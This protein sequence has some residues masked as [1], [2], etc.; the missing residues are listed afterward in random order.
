MT[1]GRGAIVQVAGPPVPHSR[2]L[3]THN[4][5]PSRTLPPPD[6][7]SPLVLRSLLDTYGHTACLKDRTVASPRLAFDFD[8][9]RPIYDGFSRTV[10][11][12][13]F[14]LSEL[15]VVL[16]LQVQSR[17]TPWMLLP[18]GLLNR[19]HHGSIVHNVDRGLRSPGDLAGRTVGV[20]AYTQTTAVWVRGLLRREFRVDLDSV[21]WI[22]FEDAHDPDHRDPPNVSRAARGEN[23][24]SMLLDGRLDAAIVARVRPAGPRIRDLIPDAEAAALAWH[25]R[26]G[27]LPINHVLVVRR[28]LVDDHPWLLA[29]LAG[30]FRDCRARYLERLRTTPS[31]EPDDVF[32]ADLLARGIDPLPFGVEAVRPAL[33]LM[34]ELCVEDGIIATPVTVDALFDPRVAVFSDVAA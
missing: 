8:E 3:T 32:R 34:I 1:R 6:G 30:L 12:G 20:R 22:T 16:W 31:L 10:G 4:T 18:I 29:E 5:S 23:L 19:F 17:G 2:G 24:D 11:T 33:E 26:T 9:V 27:I 21:R 14:D 15:A 13:D 25:A 28:Q 7:L